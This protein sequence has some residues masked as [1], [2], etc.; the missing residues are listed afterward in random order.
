MLTVWAGSMVTAAVVLALLAAYAWRRRGNECGLSLAVLL[1]AVA[2]WGLAYAVE[3]STVELG[4]RERWGDLKYVGVAM[5]GPAW[6]IF[7]LQ[8]TGRGR[9]VSRR[10]VA[11]LA[12][13]PLA[14]LVVLAVPATHDLI[15]SYPAS[16]AGE[17][18]PVVDTGALFW[19]HLVYSNL[20]VF[21]ATVLF[22]VTM[23]RLSRDYW[24]L[25]ATLV[26]A[27]LLPW[28]ANLLH[29]LEVG[30]FARLDLTP[31]AFTVT[32]GVLVWGLLRERLVNLR[33]VAWSAVV[34]TMAD[35]V[36]VL[37]AY[38]RVVD[39]NPAAARVLGRR[40]LDLPGRVLDELL[41]GHA[42]LGAG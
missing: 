13:E 25:S 38:R 16:A 35:A 18:L 3:L 10:L 26:A 6:M 14:V 42:A 5:L 8:Y 12:L 27:A 30:P 36:L 24:R 7:V 17:D 23:A 37:D 19:G 15:R 34:D 2:W 4:A 9:W 29:N 40:R 39:A 33:P 31:F 32:G 21:G 41:P 22:V 11:L 1:V 28:A 20:L